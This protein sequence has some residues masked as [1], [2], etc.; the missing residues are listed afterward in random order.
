MDKKTIAIIAVLLITAIVAGYWYGSRP[1]SDVSN[2]GKRADEAREQLDAVEQ[3]RQS[4]GNEVNSGRQ[5][6]AAGR[7][8]LTE[9][10]SIN[11]S[12]AELITECQSILRHVRARGSIS[13]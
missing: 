5:S 3:Q 1:G 4:A 7:R 11:K 9:S 2:I 10:Q 12:N 6:I 13:N 8:E